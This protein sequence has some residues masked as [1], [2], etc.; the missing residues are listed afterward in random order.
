MSSWDAAV[1]A[2]RERL[3]AAIAD[4][5]SIL[6]CGR[7]SR[8][9]RHAPA[10]APSR[11]LELGELRGLLWLDAADQTCEVG[12][13]TAPAE[14]DAWLEPHGLMLAVDAPQ[15]QAGSLGGLFLAPD[16][17]LLHRAYGPPRDQ[18]LGGSWLL[19]DGTVVRTGARVV[20]SV[21]GYDLTRLFLG[22]RGR[23]AACLSLILRLQPRPR[24]L[25]CRRVLD[26]VRLRARPLPDP[27]WFFQERAGACFAAWDGFAPTD[28]LLAPCDAEQF[29]AARAACLAAFAQAAARL[30]HARPPAAEV[31]GPMDWNSLQQA[32][33]AETPAPPAARR[34]P[35]AS[36]SPWLERLAK[37]CAPSGARFGAPAPAEAAR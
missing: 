23:L 31:A 3:R 28:A 12:A 14:L 17:S 25:Q 27:L 4:G 10:A 9:A 29:A 36:D 32:C 8:I 18:V 34:L 22:S 33:A 35:H 11:W 15:A 7:R 6:P 5:T 13:G 16:L 1:A 19:A 2:A 21:A 30:A 37:A 24:A 26:P 20:K